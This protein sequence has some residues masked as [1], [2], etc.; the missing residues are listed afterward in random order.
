ME[1]SR[2]LFR[3]VN[4]LALFMIA[5]ALLVNRGLAAPAA[6]LPAADVP[7]SASFAYSGVLLVNNNPVSSIYDL[8]FRLFD[9]ASNGRQIGSAT[10]N[11][12]SACA[13]ATTPSP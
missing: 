13:T 10:I 9:A 11:R 7:V 3:I 2:L 6:E 1:R 12:M 5:A 4:S 8:E